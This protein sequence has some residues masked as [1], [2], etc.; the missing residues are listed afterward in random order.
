MAVR[1]KSKKKHLLIKDDKIIQKFESLD[2]VKKLLFSSKGCY[3][4]LEIRSGFYVKMKYKDLKKFASIR[5]IKWTYKFCEFNEGYDYDEDDDE[6][7]DLIK[8]KYL[9]SDP[10]QIID[11][12]KN[13]NIIEHHYWYDIAPIW[14]GCYDRRC[15]KLKIT[16]TDGSTE[17]MSIHKF[18]AK[19]LRHVFY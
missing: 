13:Y 19:F 3:A 18:G 14:G 9:I 12:I 6:Y 2:K 5:S 11:I 1:A 17:K 7:F 10:I 16:Y 8:T 15:K 4:L